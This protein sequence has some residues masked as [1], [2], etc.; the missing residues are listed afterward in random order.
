MKITVLY[1]NKEGTRFDVP[2]YRD[3]HMKLVRERLTPLGLRGTAIDKGL[4]GGAPGQPPPYHCAGH[5][6]FDSLE[7]IRAFAGEDYEAAVV[8]PR[9]RAVLAR[10]DAR[11]LHYEVRADLKA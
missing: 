11:S 3:R 7:A 6:L 5:L 4:A 1:P 10:L 8:P 2:Y 9:A